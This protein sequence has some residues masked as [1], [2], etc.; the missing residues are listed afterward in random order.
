MIGNAA[1][2]WSSRKQRTTALSTVEA[3]YL[4]MCEAAKEAIWFRNILEEIGIRGKTDEPFTINVDNHG[5]ICLAK[6][7]MTSDRSK[8][9]DLRYYFLREL[10]SEGKISF[11]YVRSEENLADMLTKPIGAK[12]TKEHCTKLGLNTD[13]NEPV[14]GKCEK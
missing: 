11:Q 2:S 13:Y 12:M 8:H 7:Q 10:V 5:A 4:A 1:V 3:E 14:K 6:N 9:I